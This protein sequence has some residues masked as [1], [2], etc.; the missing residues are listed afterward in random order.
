MRFLRSYGLALL[1][2]LGI[3]AWMISGTLIEGGQ[4]AGN[5]E[6]P[7]I[8]AIEGEDGPLR[9]M[10]EAIGILQPIDEDAE[11]PVTAVAQAEIE[12]DL[13]SVRVSTYTAQDMPQIIQLRGRTEANAT[14]A[15]RAETSGNVQEMHV[16]KGQTVAAGDLLCTLDQGTRQASLAQAE[17]Q[18]AQAQA[19]L[20]N[21]TA[22]RERGVAAPNTARQYEVALASAQAAYEQA[23]AELERTEITATVSGVV[24]EPMS[25]LGAYLSAGSECATVVQLDPMVFVGQVPEARIGALNE[26]DQAQVTTV[27]GQEVVGAVRFIAATADAASRTFTVEIELPNADGTIRDG[28]TADALIQTGTIMAHLVPQ[29]VLTLDTAGTLGVRAVVDEDTVEFFPIEVA[30]DTREGMWVTGLPET[31]DIIT[32]G[33]EFVQAGQ[34]V[35]VSR[36]EGALS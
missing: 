27:T 18:L 34:Q 28:V 4:G 23:L 33:Q 13:Q 12:D 25:E 1:I 19:D 20:E 11:A 17:A 10:L 16:T 24:Q 31:V 36:E 29:S 9:P 22:L 35:T 5:G 32:L 21:N 2:V 26:G 14:V 30:R 6:Q 3:A 8:D 7:L 15:V